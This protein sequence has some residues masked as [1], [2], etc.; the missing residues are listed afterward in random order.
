[1]QIPRA[2]GIGSTEAFISV[3]V[4][5]FS[6]MQPFAST[7]H[8]K[9]LDMFQPGNASLNINLRHS[10]IADISDQCQGQY[11]VEIKLSS[12]YDWLILVIT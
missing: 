2:I 4:E 8:T 9:K 7:D 3:C 1:M 10:N 11:N 12:A 6:S 5:L